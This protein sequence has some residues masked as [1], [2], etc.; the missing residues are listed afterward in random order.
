MVAAVLVRRVL[1]SGPGA[2]GLG[3]AYIFA[4]VCESPGDQQCMGFDFYSIP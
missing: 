2:A 4:I 3:R 1:V